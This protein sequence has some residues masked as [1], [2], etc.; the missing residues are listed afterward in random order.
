MYKNRCK[1]ILYTFLTELLICPSLWTRQEPSYSPR[2]GE[3]VNIKVPL[4]AGSSLQ[5]F[6]NTCQVH[7]LLILQGVSVVSSLSNFSITM[8][9][10]EPQQAEQRVTMVSLSGCLC[11]CVCDACES[12]H[13]WTWG[14]WMCMVHKAERQF[15]CI[16]QDCMHN[17]ACL[18]PV[19][20]ANSHI[21]M[22]V[23][24]CQ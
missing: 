11:V 13:I 8:G 20:A 2:V 14:S 17:T 4:H 21:C 23:V 9:N 18:Q 19:C 24:T 12:V 5:N 22:C 7:S 10:R 1:Y 16:N 3:I 15:L 6:R